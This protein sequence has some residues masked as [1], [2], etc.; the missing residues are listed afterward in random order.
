[1]GLIISRNFIMLAPNIEESR[2]SISEKAL[3]NAPA[4]A[5]LYC[6]AGI[7]SWGVETYGNIEVALAIEPLKERRRSYRKRRQFRPG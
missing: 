1:M 6:S 5:D 7:G 4:M 3:S 2:S